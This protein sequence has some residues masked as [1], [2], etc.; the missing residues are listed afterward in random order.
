[1][2]NIAMYQYIK[3]AIGFEVVSNLANPSGSPNDQI[4]FVSI[5]DM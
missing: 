4:V 3:N 2:K 5:L 1:M